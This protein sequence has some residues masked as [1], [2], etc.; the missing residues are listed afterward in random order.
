MIYDTYRAIAQGHKSPAAFD[1]FHGLVKKR[2]HVQHLLDLETL[3]VHPKHAPQLDEQAYTQRTLDALR[4]REAHARARLPPRAVPEEERLAS[5]RAERAKRRAEHGILGRKSLPHGLPDAL[6]AQVR[7]TFQQRGVIASMTGAQVESHDLA[8]LRPG[9]WLND[10]VINFY[11]NLIMQ[12]ANDAEAKR[13]AARQKK[14]VPPADCCGY[15]SV[16]FFSSFFWQKL[17]SQGYKGVQRWSRRVDLFTKDLILLPINLGQAHWVCAAINLRLRRFEYYD[18][19]AIARPGVFATLR[20]YLAEELKAKHQ[21]TLDL[22]DW[23]DF[24]A[25]DTSPQQANGYDCGVFAIQT[26]EQL[27]RRD[28]LEAMSPPLSAALF[29]RPA[30]AK[31]LRAEREAH[32]DDYAWNF[33]QEHMPYLRRRMACEIASKRLLE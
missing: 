12:R 16:H 29:D 18:S 2:M 21:L 23:E 13:S 31:A 22:S 25:G 1:D 15:W 33:A 8:K 24:F 28:P 3:R 10:E 14:E 27:S 6:E 30:D 9:Q 7:S 32:A 4:A 5:L 20:T 17:Q 19:M 26:L 11:G